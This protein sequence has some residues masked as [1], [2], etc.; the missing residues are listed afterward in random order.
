MSCCF[1]G[2][3]CNP[4]SQSCGICPREA[5]FG[6]LKQVASPEN[7]DKVQREV[8]ALENRNPKFFQKKESLAIPNVGGGRSPHRDLNSEPV[9]ETKGS[10]H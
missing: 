6:P 3:D 5:I 1:C 9:V 4:L 7:V 2:R 10:H 8:V